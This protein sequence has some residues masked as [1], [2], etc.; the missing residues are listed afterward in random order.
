[1][2]GLFSVL[3]LLAACS[4]T[5]EP[6]P[7]ARNGN[8]TIVPS[9]ASVTPHATVSASVTA[10]PSSPPSAQVA[11]GP[12]DVGYDVPKSW[13]VTPSTNP[14]RKA[15]IK[16]ADDTELA[17]STAMGGVDANVKRWAAQFG[18]AQPKTEKKKVNGLD[19][20][21]VELAGEYVSG[22]PVMGGDGQPKGN[23]A[24]LGA[25]VD[26][27]DK[28]HFFKMVGPAKNVSAARKDFDAFVA[29][30]RAK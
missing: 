13:T 30:F 9:D 6:E 28:Q 22:G 10:A 26:A 21:I 3:V 4:K 18:G 27:G 8:D 17:V 7:P 29:S 23:Y 19:V 1:M 24:L 20:T 16:V 5:A 15:T 12:D 25:I 2:K 11:K 14:M